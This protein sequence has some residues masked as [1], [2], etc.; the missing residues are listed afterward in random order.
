MALTAE[1]EALDFN[2]E[3]Q[4]VSRQRKL[5]ELLMAKG[6]QQPQG[7]MISGH[8]VAPSWTQQ[9]NPMANILAGEAVGERADTKQSELA[10]ALRTQGNSAVQKVMETF[11]QNPQLGV[12]E[13]AKLQQF[14][15]VKALLPTLAKALELTPEE[16]QYKAAI[17]D[18][19]FEGGFNAFKNQMTDA[20][21]ESARNERIKTGIAQQE[22]N[23]NNAPYNPASFGQP[24][25]Q[26]PQQMPQNAPQNVPINPAM[27]PTGLAPNAPAYAQGAVN[28]PVNQGAPQA[29]QV[30]P[31][32]Q[33]VPQPPAWVRTQKD[34][35]DWL[36]S[37]SEP[38]NEFQ[39]KAVLFGSSMKQANNVIDQ[40]SKEG[41]ITP[42]VAP[43]FLS[44]I[45]KLAPL[46]VGDAA[47][48]AIQAAFRQD[49]TGF[50]GPDKNQQ[51]LAQAQLGFAI[52]YLRQTSGASFGAQEVANTI[53]EFFPL[54]GESQAV[55]DQK[56]A[57]RKRVIESMKAVSG[58]GARQI[59]EL[60]NISASN[61]GWGKA[62]VVKN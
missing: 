30:N 11:N 37:E 16:R 45:A 55:I 51:R 9:L 20:Q 47:A 35:K 14:P 4:D 34:Y 32:A 31:Q 54:I 15:Q 17:A 46:G 57:S 40:L 2:P 61:S 28:F 41:T 48:N 44:G 19:S 39:G 43:E 23:L 24:A 49:P 27:K 50:V 8:Y 13:A 53:A 6:M 3:L 1:Q 59:D 42:A 7:Q 52:P 60:G 26:M 25:R 62:E 36:K 38:L 56:A 22:F 58:R 18:K 33:T 10:T 21:K 12:Q 29:A 5:A